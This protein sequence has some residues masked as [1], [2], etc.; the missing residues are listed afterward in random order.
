MND[1]PPVI[2][3]IYHE[4]LMKKSNE[5]RMLMGFSMHESAKQIAASSIKDKRN[6]RVE[7]FKRFYK[8][9][10]NEENQKKIIAR[11]KEY[12]KIN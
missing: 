5:E 11:I 6:L 3:K 10:F 4:M 7:L 12:E 9:D 2:K 8:N 1:T